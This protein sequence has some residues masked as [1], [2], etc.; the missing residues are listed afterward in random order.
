MNILYLPVETVKREL[1]SK[2]AIGLHAL[3]FDQFDEVIIGKDAELFLCITEPGVILL[4]SAASFESGLIS[5]LKEFGHIVYS[6]DEEG[7]VPPLNDPSINSRFSKKNLDLLDG[8]L[9]NGPLELQSFPSWVRES[10]KIIMSGNPR[11]DFYKKEN[12]A[13][14]SKAVAKIRSEIGDKKVILIASRFG[15]VN[16]VEGQSCYEI[17]SDNG[18]LDTEESKRFFSGFLEHSEKV[19]NSFLELP[20]LIADAFPE[21]TIVVRPHPSESHEKWNE[22]SKRTNIIVRSDYDIGSWLACSECLIHNGCTTAIEASVMQVPVLSYLPVKSLEFDL[23]HPNEIGYEINKADDLLIVVGNVL[24]YSEKYCGVRKLDSILTYDMINP[25]S[26]LILNT[27]ASK[28]PLRKIIKNKMCF[29]S[30]FSY[31]VKCV[32]KLILHCLGIRK[33]YKRAKYPFLFQREYQERS[34]S[35]AKIFNLSVSYSLRKKGIDLISIK[36]KGK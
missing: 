8:V 10:D 12:R 20:S 5:R 2:L 32:F 34:K 21:C 24:N 30:F 13:Y 14:Y 25:A 29:K 18:F 26:R 19:F 28:K 27:L 31:Y 11:F 36:K 15:D 16:I 22:V 4:K 6:L 17:L 35:I 7:I 9:C 1:D 23:H 3:E 33:E